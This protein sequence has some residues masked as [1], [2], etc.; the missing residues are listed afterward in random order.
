M[1][2]S[3][4]E[5][6]PSL[7]ISSTTRFSDMRQRSGRPNTRRINIQYRPNVAKD[8]VINIFNI[9]F[10][11]ILQ[12]YNNILTY[13]PIITKKSCLLI[14]V[15]LSKSHKFMAADHFKRACISFLFVDIFILTRFVGSNKQIFNN[16]VVMVSYF[17]VQKET[18]C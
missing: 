5:L 16:C 8:D 17:F 6:M 4:M 11:F 18:I 2:T 14:F 13:H 1:I 3:G 15:N 9:F 10:Y 12:I 7:L